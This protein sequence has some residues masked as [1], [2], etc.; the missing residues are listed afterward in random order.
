ML[1]RMAPKNI[2]V[3]HELSLQLHCGRK[4]S[5]RTT[6]RHDKAAESANN[7]EE[8]FVSQFFNF[9]RKLPDIVISHV[10]ICHTPF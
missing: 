5:R 4:A 2:K 6:G 8:Q 10:S 3:A 7:V 1:K 9:M